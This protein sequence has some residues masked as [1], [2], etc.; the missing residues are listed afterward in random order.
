MA[1]RVFEALLRNDDYIDLTENEVAPDIKKGKYKIS[2]AKLS[3]DA[4]IKDNNFGPGKAKGNIVTVPQDANKD[5]EKKLKIT[6]NSTI[7]YSNIPRARLFEIARKILKANLRKNNIDYKHIPLIKAA[8]GYIPNFAKIQSLSGPF[9]RWNTNYAGMSEEDVK[10]SFAGQKGTDFSGTTAG[11]HNPFIGKYDLLENNLIASILGNNTFFS[12][13]QEDRRSLENF[14]NVLSAQGR[15]K[16]V[17]FMGF[18]QAV[19]KDDE[20]ISGLISGNFKNIKYEKLKDIFPRLWRAKGVGNVWDEVKKE[21][22]ER[23]GFNYL[24]RSSLKEPT[25]ILRDAAIQAVTKYNNVSGFNIDLTGSA[26]KQLLDR[27]ISKDVSYLT[28]FTGSGISDFKNL[29]VEKAKRKASLD[30]ERKLQ[31]IEEYKKSGILYRDFK[32]KE[33]ELR[34]LGRWGNYDSQRK[35]I[36][37][38]NAASGYIPNFA[39]GPLMDAIQREKLESGLPLSAISVVKDN[40]LIGSQN[41]AGLGV[42][43]KRDEPNGRIPNFAANTPT[44]PAIIAAFEDAIKSLIKNTGDL[45]K[46]IE[47]TAKNGENFGFTIENLNKGINL[48]LENKNPAQA[49][50]ENSAESD[51]KQKQKQEIESSKELSEQKKKEIKSVQESTFSILK[52]QAML[53]FTQGALSAFGP[54]AE[55]AGQAINDFGSAIYT[56]KESS[57]LVSN[58]A[59]KGK[60]SFKE[61]DAGIAFKKAKDAAGGNIKGVI[62]GTA[63]ALATEG[64]VAALAGATL[65]PVLIAATAG[66]LAIKG[67]DSAIEALNGSSQKTA[68]ALEMVEQAQ[69]KYQI[70]LTES[71]KR[72]IENSVSNLGKGTSIGGAY[73]RYFGGLFSISMSD[74]EKNLI[75]AGGS[76]GLQTEG[77]KSIASLI[78]SSYLPQIEM[79]MKEE[80]FKSNKAIGINTKFEDIKLNPDSVQNA[81]N[82]KQ[83]DILRQAT[84]KTIRE[85]VTVAQKEL[86]LF[87]QENLAEIRKQQKE[88]DKTGKTGDTLAKF[89][90]LTK[91]NI[92]AVF[93]GGRSVTDPTLLFKNL[94]DMIQSD[95]KIAKET[96]ASDKTFRESFLFSTELLK[97]QLE[98][99]QQIEKINSSRMT[100]EEAI[101]SIRK[102]LL[103]TSETEKQ[104]IEFKLQSLQEEKNYRSEIK[105]ATLSAARE[106]VST[107]ISNRGNQVTEEQATNIKNIFYEN[108]K[109]AGQDTE[110]IKD[111]FND[112]VISLE[113]A[114]FKNEAFVENLKVQGEILQQNLNTI[115]AQSDARKFQNAIEAQN[116]SILEQQNYQY[117]IQKEFLQG[118]INAAQ[119]ELDIRRELRDIENKKKDISFERS[120][121]REPDRIVSQQKQFYDAQRN[122]ENSLFEIQ[123][124][125]ASSFLQSKNNTMAFLEKRGIKDIG[126]YEEV[127][128]AKSNED[129]LKIAK[130]A[131]ETEAKGF[132][133]RVTN[134]GNNF[135]KVV[136]DAA[137]K[138]SVSLGGKSNEE[139]LRNRITDLNA[140]IPVTQ[141]NIQN[142]LNKLK[143]ERALLLDKPDLD[144][145]DDYYVKLN[146]KINQLTEAFDKAAEAKK[147]FDIEKVSDE[148]IKNI[149]GILPGQTNEKQALQNAEDQ[150]RLDIYKAQLEQYK[151][152]TF[153]GGMLQSA[154]QM[155]EEIDTFGNKLGKEIPMNFRDSMVQAMKDISSGTKSVKD[156]L[157]SAAAAFLQKINDA[158]MTNM[159]N[160]IVQPITNMFGNIGAPAFASGGLISGGSGTKDDVPSMLM[161]GEFVINKKAV[162]AYGKD[163]F[164]KLNSGQLKKFAS[165]GF[166]PTKEL[167]VTDYARNPQKY[168]PYGQ[169]RSGK[170]SFDEQGNLIGDLSY[171]GKEENKEYAL[172]KAQTDFYAKNAQTRTG[173][174]FLIPGQEGSGAIIGQRNLLAF[175]TQEVTTPKYDRL[176]SSSNSASIDLMGGSTNL[177]LYALRNQ[178]DLRN[179]E[180]AD[181][182]SKAFELYLGGIDSNKQKAYIAEQER[183]A[184]EER[185]KAEAEQR[186]N[187]W[188]SIGLQFAIGV[189]M[190]FLGSY[191]GNAFNSGQQSALNSQMKQINS[192]EFLPSNPD[193]QGATMGYDQFGKAYSTTNTATIANTKLGG[194][195]S[196]K[197]GFGGIGNK[198]NPFSESIGNA[199]N[200]VM[201]NNQPYSWSNR[202]YEPMNASKINWSNI[203]YS[204]NINGLVPFT[205]SKYQMPPSKI[206]KKASG[207]YISGNG[208]G[209]N[210]PTMLNGGEFVISKQAAEKTGYGNLQ[211]INSGNSK[212]SDM[213]DLISRLEKKLEDLITKVSGIGSIS[214][215]VTTSGGSNSSMSSQ[216]SSTGQDSQKQKELAR[217]IK[218]TVLSVLRDEKRIGGLLR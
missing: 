49:L 171:T 99:Y 92:E 85:Q 40:K 100:S 75:K 96:A 189:G 170:Y 198:L 117:S 145:T 154:D 157:L 88:E 174:G 121:V 185:K 216:E 107:F 83:A 181:A 134:A 34:K 25:K 136:S 50:T 66:A 200:T 98:S 13:N 211:K 39:Q 215:N 213:E 161:G 143:E 180:F 192:S 14:A 144:P 82:Q 27:K 114:G 103:S 163:F 139:I 172:K 125:N 56:L 149:A 119:K 73:N 6:K 204:Q 182:K 175:A 30:E 8:K 133:D 112:F 155:R 208:M 86:Q 124:K 101:L 84:E 162:Q 18:T 126:K 193:I 209:D 51:K 123:Q 17:G 173:E 76:T 127:A 108:L 129:L 206:Q 207:G 95:S 137:D 70:S 138:V 44:D 22:L 186:K 166:V 152:N 68:A 113:T 214:I 191:L 43:N 169:S 57:D 37:L 47:Q 67:L 115:K 71:Q 109:N 24:R 4:A 46:A 197:A 160:K 36:Y 196:I 64:G 55:K 29:G 35:V 183:K 90:E 150:K 65:G 91:K 201:Y 32:N 217:T 89:K 165:G 159:A 53:S 7:N 42:I 48:A 190:N 110:K 128:N 9:S 195:D 41:P 147:K 59:F 205:T 1:G 77:N 164:N 21:M 184:E 58:L 135:Y 105:D 179:K 151:Q 202:G 15:S 176:S 168:S 102:E 131:L 97:K 146:K 23:K 33:V 218:D 212:N 12:P 140:P 118:K 45:D 178:D 26:D 106:Q 111:S 79:K 74:A 11:E 31:K 60:A 120:M 94:T 188:K 72:T 132:D 80:Q 153:G 210:V 78:G 5:L 87:R 63:A 104:N 187:M 16:D 81:L 122:Y 62:G 10:S 199:N 69:A 116:K 20:V 141:N 38:L 203:Q 54:A 52:W 158:L 61:T 130:S 177:S 19:T 194:W 2:E 167:N 28:P 93:N 148:S 142:D 3:L 156:G